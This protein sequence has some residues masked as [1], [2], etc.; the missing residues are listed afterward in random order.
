MNS[1][2]SINLIFR[3]AFAKYLRLR[4][5][6]LQFPDG[7][8][9]ASVQVR[10]ED[11][12]MARTLYK[13]RKPACRS[14][15][16]FKPLKTRLA[17][18]CADC[19]MRETCTPQICLQLSVEQVPYDLLLSYSSLRNFLFFRSKLDRPIE[20]CPVEIRVRN[21]GKWGEVTFKTATT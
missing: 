17:K 2:V 16:G 9:Q 3:R 14:L 21:R 12:H 7:H 19:L 1:P 6:G 4:P 13:N 18:H 8:V 11:H 15:D 10:I 20:K 5:D